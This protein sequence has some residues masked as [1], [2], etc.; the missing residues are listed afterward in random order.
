[1]TGVVKVHEP[2]GVQTFRSEL[3]VEALD[4]AV[5]GWLA[6]SREVQGNVI[7]ISPQIEIAG[8][9]FRTLIIRSD[10]VMTKASMTKSECFREKH[11]GSETRN[12]SSSKL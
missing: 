9:K 4:E 8:Y 5:I 1:L 12:I 2:V 3:A 11:T 6:W 7:G 10:W